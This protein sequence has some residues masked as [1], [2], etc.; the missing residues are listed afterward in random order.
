MGQRFYLP[1]L[2]LVCVV[3]GALRSITG[4]EVVGSKKTQISFWNGWTGPDGTAML[5]VIRRFNEENPDVEVSMQRMDWATYYNKLMVSEVSGRGPQVFVIHAST[6]PRMRRAG[7]VGDVS[8]VFGPKTGI[9]KSDFDDKVYQEVEYGSKI[10][11]LPLDIHP[12]G[13]YCNSDMLLAAGWKNADGTPRPPTNLKEFLQCIHD[14]EK[15][16][17]DGSY[18]PWGFSWSMWHNNYLS[19]L[20]QFHG[21][22]YDEKG[23]PDLANPGNVRALAFMGDLMNKMKV[24]PPP[25]SNLG[26]IGFRQKHVAMEWDGVYMLGDLQRLDD[27]K[28]VGAP[29]PQIGDQ[30]GTK[31]DSHCLCIRSGMSDKEREASE[32]F[33]VYLSKHSIEWAKAGQVPARISIRNT[34]EFRAMKVQYQFSRQIP[35]MM[36]EPSTPVLFEL[37]LEIDQAI[38]KVLR[39]HATPKEALELANVNFKKAI[40]RDKEDNKA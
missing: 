2:F 9:L 18:D 37:D 15:A 35:W 20:P 34:P 5:R 8:D 27:F 32:R 39:G 17:P 33:I 13:M 26:W 14:T 31:A 21:H 24:V 11:G 7:F 16:Q 36:Y 12:Q 30:P 6:L 22:Y 3:L 23:Q 10:V 1:A 29:I 28:Y 25:E 40:E 19:L 38:E 4:G